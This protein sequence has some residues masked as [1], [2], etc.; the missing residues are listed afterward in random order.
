M[1]LPLEQLDLSKSA[2]SQEKFRTRRIIPWEVSGMIFYLAAII[3]FTLAL[4]P[5]DTRNL[6]HRVDF[7]L[8]IG[9][10]VLLG[11]MLGIAA[12]KT[13]AIKRDADYR[14]AILVAVLE[15]SSS[16]PPHYRP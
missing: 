8:A 3:G 12:F 10:V 1:P 13:N 14:R 15:G 6:V 7:W 16:A 4:D 5:G 11:V 2:D 9:L